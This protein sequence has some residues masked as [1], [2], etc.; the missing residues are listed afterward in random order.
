M[1]DQEVLAIFQQH[2]P[3][4]AEQMQKLGLSLEWVSEGTARRVYHINRSLAVKTAMYSLETQTEREIE[5]T[6]E[7]YRNPKYEHLRMYV[8][9]LLYSNKENR[10]LVTRYYPHEVPYPGSIRTPEDAKKR[11]QALAVRDI[12]ESSEISG[13]MH[14][15]NIRLDDQG[16][17]YVVDLGYFYIPVDPDPIV[18]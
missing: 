9:P 11:R 12:V 15:A 6:E 10:V 4:T 7:I 2:H 13:D 8:P 14:L 5:I 1:R 18:K 3:A 17:A 16:N